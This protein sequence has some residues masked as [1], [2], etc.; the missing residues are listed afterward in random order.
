ML[1]SQSHL[2]NHSVDGDSCPFVAVDCFA[3]IVL[4]EPVVAAVFGAVVAQGAVV[5]VVVAALHAE[6]VV[7]VELGRC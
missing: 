4:A 3:E 1:S 7:G 2:C 5:V 6:A